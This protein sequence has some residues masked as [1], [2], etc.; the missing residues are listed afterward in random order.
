MREVQWGIWVGNQ[1]ALEVWKG[2]LEEAEP[3]A[4]AEQDIYILTSRTGWAMARW[5][6]RDG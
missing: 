2:D 4:T 6:A 1:E 3:P 5:C